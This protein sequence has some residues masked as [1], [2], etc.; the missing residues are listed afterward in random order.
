MYLGSS[1][2]VCSCLV[3]VITDK[4]TQNFGGDNLS[5]T[6]TNYRV[7]TK[8][9]RTNYCVSCNNN[10]KT[11]FKPWQYVRFESEDYLCVVMHDVM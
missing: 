10:N 3:F 8:T 5:E 11:P 7:I 6:R 1:S 2:V 4:Q 9:P